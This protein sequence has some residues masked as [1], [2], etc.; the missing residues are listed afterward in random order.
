MSSVDINQLRN[1]LAKVTIQPPKKR[2]KKRGQ[3]QPPTSIPG[4]MLPIVV[5]KRNGRRRKR[6][7][8]NFANSGEVTLSRTELLTSVDI[9]TNKSEIA[10][11]V[12]LYPTKDTMSWLAKVGAAFDRIV[13]LRAKVIW[14]PCVGTTANGSIVFGVDWNSSTGKAPERPNVQALTPVC[15]NAVWQAAVVTLPQD[16]LMSRKNYMLNTTTKQDRQPGTFLYHAKGAAGS[17][18]D[19][20]IEYTV[21]LSGTQS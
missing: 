8:N 2:R 7:L 20:W 11:F 14:K 6:G 10:N 12:D 13:W 1:L 18:G 15:E 16:R 5:S 21:K 17:I 4:A 3:A 19:F 9:P